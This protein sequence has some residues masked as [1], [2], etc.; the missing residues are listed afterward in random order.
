MVPPDP[1]AEDRPDLNDDALVEEITL[2]GDMIVAASTEPAHLSET[3]VDS[4][5]GLG[6]EQA[7]GTA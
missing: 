7:D 1:G 6:D 5:L 3:Q 2:L 4:A